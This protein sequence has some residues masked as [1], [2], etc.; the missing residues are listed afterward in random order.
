MLQGNPGCVAADVHQFGARCPPPMRMMSTF[1]GVV[2][3]VVGIFLI[4]IDDLRN[5]SP[6]TP[7]EPTSSDRYPEAR[8]RDGTLGP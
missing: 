8:P 3:R 7:K 5:R 4:A 1:L 6:V 2:T